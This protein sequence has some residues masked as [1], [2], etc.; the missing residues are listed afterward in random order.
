MNG[1]YQQAMDTAQHAI[2]LATERNDV[3]LVTDLR[4]NLDRYQHQ[5]AQAATG[6]QR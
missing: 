1:R 2:D 5:A 6:N 3:T 4:A